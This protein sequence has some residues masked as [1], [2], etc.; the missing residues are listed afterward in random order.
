MTSFHPYVCKAQLFLYLNIPLLANSNFSLSYYNQVFSDSR[1]TWSI[2]L[3]LLKPDFYVC[4]TVTN[5]YGGMMKGIDMLKA[6]HEENLVPKRSASII[7][8]LTDGQPNV[9]KFVLGE[10]TE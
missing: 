9:G 4:L 6:A 3:T 1:E 7:I 10:I 8:M 2:I 5:L